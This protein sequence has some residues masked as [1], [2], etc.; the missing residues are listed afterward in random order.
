MAQEIERK[1]LVLNNDYKKGITGTLYKQGYLCTDPQ[2]TI[3]IRTVGN[4]GYLT[5]KGISKGAV[6]AEYEYSIPYKDAE[7]LFCLCEKPLIEKYR[8]KV[9]YAGITWEVDE[10]C[11]DNKGLVIAEVELD[12]ENQPVEFPSWVGLEVTSDKRY[13]NSNLVRLPFNHS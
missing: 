2:R 9:S 13:Y 5:I 12:F 1:F 11:G 7:E 4:Q 6:C 8:Y 3:R 10:F